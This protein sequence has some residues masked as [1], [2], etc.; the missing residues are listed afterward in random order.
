MRETFQEVDEE[1]AARVKSWL[2][3]GAED[4]GGVDSYNIQ[5]GLLPILKCTSWQQSTSPAVAQG[6][7]TNSDLPDIY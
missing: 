6:E 5:P 3:K 2:Q 7:V 1:L 4:Q